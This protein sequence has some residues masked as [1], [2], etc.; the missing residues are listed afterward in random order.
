MDQTWKASTWEQFGAAL[1]M[2]EQA[3][4]ACPDELWG[5][6]SR[7]PEFWYIVFHTLFYLDLYLSDSAEGF[8]PPA[9]F[10]LDE[11][12]DRGLMPDRVYTKKELLEYLE[13]G[14]QKCR[15][16]IASLTEEGAERRSGFRWL[17]MPVAAAHLYNLRHLQHHVG[18]LYLL[19]RQTVD[20]TP[21]WIRKATVAL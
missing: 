18:Q 12:D 14:R 20:A 11:L 13:H 6:R 21:G 4:H 19:L 7:R 8:T 17:D 16:R 2:L 1:D 5:E 9:P 3:V 10:T 15:S